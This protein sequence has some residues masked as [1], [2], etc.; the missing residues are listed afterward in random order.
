VTSTGSLPSAD[1]RTIDETV[2]MKHPYERS[3]NGENRCC[4]RRRVSR[5]SPS[6]KS[7]SP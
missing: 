3:T 7:V 5:P 4:G 2:L 6:E 1:V